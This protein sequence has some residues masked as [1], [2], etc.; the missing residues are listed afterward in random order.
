LLRVYQRFRDWSFGGHLG[1]G[2]FAVVCDLCWKP[3]ISP[4]KP[5]RSQGSRKGRKDQ[6]KSPDPNIAEPGES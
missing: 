2:H 3:A 1:R 4:A 5:P 6:K